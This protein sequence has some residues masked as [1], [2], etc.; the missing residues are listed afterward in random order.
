MKAPN[1]VVCVK[2][3]PDSAQIRVHPVTGTIMRQG[4]PAVLNPYDLFALEEALQIKDRL[5]G[6][7]VALCMGPSQ[8][9][10]VLRK[11]LSLGA[12]EAVLVSDRAFAGSDTLATSFA[13]ARAI[14]RLSQ[15]RAVD[16]VFTGK[17]TIDG[18]TGQ[19]GPGVA[20]RLGVQL[21]SYV[22]RIP[23][24]DMNS[25]S[26]VVHRWTEK[27]VQVLSSRLPCLITVL[28]GTNEGRFASLPE[29]IRAARQPIRVWDRKAAGIEDVSKIGLKGSPTV[30]GKVFAPSRRAERAECIEWDLEEPEKAVAELW[31]KV[32]SRQPELAAKCSGGGSEGKREEGDS[33]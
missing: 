11:A 33:E 5:G 12:D 3:V 30:V 17:Q 13:L 25:R 20:K 1:I 27:G 31:A 7:I 15:E 14:A 32:I 10:A 29:M 2:Q 23:V 4:V 19:V 8:A 22:C 21:L 26:I 24:L 9:E 18:D 16:L 28:E 6:W